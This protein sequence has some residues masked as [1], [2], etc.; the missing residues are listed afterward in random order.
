MDIVSSFRIEFLGMR[1]HSI[2]RLLD[3]RKFK[4]DESVQCW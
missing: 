4:L 3:A 1:L 2:S